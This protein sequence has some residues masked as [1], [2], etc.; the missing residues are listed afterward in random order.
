MTNLP[1]TGQFKVNLLYGVKGDYKNPQ[2]IHTGIDL[3]GVPDSNTNI[4]SVCDG[5]VKFAG[6]SDDYGN[7]VKIIDSVTGK[8]FLFAHLKS[9]TVKAGDIV[10]RATIIGEMGN[11]GNSTGPHLHLEMRTPA[12]IYGQQ[13]NP[14][15]YIMG[16]SNPIVGKIYNS[17]DFQITPPA[18]IPNMMYSAHCQNLGWQ[19]EKRNGDWAGLLG[20]GLRV[21][22]LIINADINIQY[23]VHMAGKGW[24]DWVPNG[25]MAGT[26]GESRAIEAIEIQ[27][28][29]N[30]IVGQAYVENIGYQ[31]EVRGT[32][33]TIG[34]TGQAL[35]I[36][37][38]RLKFE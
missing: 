13:E 5:I 27:S 19:E 2:K 16:I 26:I 25:C 37:A 38:F 21:E 29:R 9:Y 4:Y 11:T 36:E 8:V 30:V 7:Y 20:Q 12:D 17:E 32:Q 14:A 18:P 28:S 15:P 6:P 22:A 1:F 23:R 10:S 3:K 33:I 35:R 31:N 34:T 24:S